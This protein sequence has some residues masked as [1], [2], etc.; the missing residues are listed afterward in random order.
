MKDLEHDE[1]WAEGQS[2]IAA[3]DRRSAC[4]DLLVRKK[5]ERC[6]ECGRFVSKKELAKVPRNGVPWCDD[7]ASACDYPHYY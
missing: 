2:A 3:E 7:C 5:R 1:N 4:S 6:Y